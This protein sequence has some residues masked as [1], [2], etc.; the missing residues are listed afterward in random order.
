[1]YGPF[2]FCSVAFLCLFT[3]LLTLRVMLEQERAELDAL[4]LAQ[5]D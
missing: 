5:E 1:M 2:L 3:L 4:Y